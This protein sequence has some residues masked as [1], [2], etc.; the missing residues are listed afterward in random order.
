MNFLRNIS[1]RNAMIAIMGAFVVVLFIVAIGKYRVASGDFQ[2]VIRIE[3]ANAM[4]DDII[5][6]ARQQAI[7]RGVTA[8]AL[9]SSGRSSGDIINKIGNLRSKSEAALSEAMAKA[10]KL[11]QIDPGNMELKKAL[12]RVERA[13]ANV[14]SMR[15]NVDTELGKDVKGIEPA[16]WA[17]VMTGLIEATADL[18]IE[19]LTSPD[20]HHTFHS[21][22]KSNL[23]LKHSS[24]L[25]GEYAGRERAIIAPHIKNGKAIGEETHDK[26]ISYRSITE[27]SLK[28]LA[29]LKESSQNHPELLQSLNTMENIFLGSY[30]ETRKAVYN[31][32]KTGDYS[33]SA[34]EW[35][36][37]ATEGINS[38]VAVADAVSEIVKEDIA[39]GKAEIIRDKNM[40][41]L[42]MAVCIFLAVL[43]FVVLR[44]KVFKPMQNLKR[45]NEAIS[46]VEKTG[47][48]RVRIEC[49]SMDE[50]GQIASAFNKML[51]NF[52]SI[53]VDMHTSSDHLTLA[54]QELSTTATQISQ[55]AGEQS[56][57]AEHVAT[58]SQEMSATIIE[59]AKN[60]SGASDSAQEANNAA[61]NGSEVVLRT[62]E[63]MNGIAL[64]ARE[65]S[66]VIFTLGTRSKEIGKI[67][68]VIED[69]ADQTNLL[70]LN[71]A[72]EA[73]RAGE[74][75][76]GFAVVADE[77]R[78]LAERTG[79]A[80]KEIGEM[81]KAIQ[82]ETEKA[83]VTMDKEVQVVEEGVSLAEETGNSL[84][85]ITGM[86]E[87]V[88]C[89]IG[90]IATAS[91]EQ[92][93]AADQ[94]SGD[95]E[96]VARISK[97]ATSSSEQ[98]VR[99]S[100]EM[101]ELAQNLQRAVSVFKVSEGADAVVKKPEI[102]EATTPVTFKD[103][104]DKASQ[105][106]KIA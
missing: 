16:V 28:T 6:S 71:A 15:R 25:A 74:Q 13:H 57:R 40:A 80:T 100:H 53:V 87:N 62:I 3:T 34:S 50:T 75:G 45:I 32:S 37:A 46:N 104:R 48:L 90:Q 55:G 93:V 7:E 27:H 69:I 49:N 78:K 64:T 63:S 88:T 22:L 85:E 2:E 41:L 19:A 83:T 68:K 30:E 89:V 76:R 84:R 26:L 44:F 1:I 33:L 97:E 8:A 14:L 81:I 72:I 91:E 86:V 102:L 77:V 11:T 31:Q 4:A 60:T 67:I 17:D 9:S 79:T 24:W 56:S 47:D 36:S 10:A 101:S 96:S 12:P 52:H 105:M 5:S 99:A 103:R 106:R 82:E 95:I 23:L 39:E 98:I 70:A 20:E 18:R 35:I 51:D 38:I 43:S 66:E 61:C 65:S 42:T 94:I 29:K 21:P 73:A 58:A 59:V 54:S 92:S